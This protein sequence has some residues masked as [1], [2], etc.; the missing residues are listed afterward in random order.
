MPI[1]LC[2]FV[3]PPLACPVPA[4]VPETWL[5]CPSSSCESNPRAGRPVPKQLLVS[6]RAPQ[7]S[8]GPGV[9]GCGMTRR[10]E[11]LHA[12]TVRLRRGLAELDEVVRVLVSAVDPGVDDGELD[13]LRR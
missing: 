9:A 2:V 6:G 12:D 3:M 8:R 10:A 4:T 1:V 7:R 13:I 5:P 11:D